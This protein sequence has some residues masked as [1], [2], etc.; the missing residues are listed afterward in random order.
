MNQYSNFAIEECQVV[1][2]NA[3]RQDQ[4]R[5]L[6]RLTIPDK[7]NDLRSGRVKR[8]L[9]VDVETTGLSMENDDV[10]QLAML[11]F[12]YDPDTGRVLTVHKE[13]AFE[14]LRET[15][16]PI[17]EEASLV[18]GIT[19]EMIRGKFIDRSVVNEI[20]EPVDFVVAHNASFDRP[21]VERHWPRFAEKPWG[22]TLTGIEWLREGFSAGKLDYLGMQFGWFFDG[23]RAL[24]DCE[25]C[26][27]LLAQELPKS[28]TQ[29]LSV[30]REAAA[31]NDFL[32]RASGAPFDE[33]E[34]LKQR[35]YRWRPDDLPNGKVWWTIVDDQQA[36][37]DWLRSEVYK[38]DAVIPV[39]KVS[40]LERYSDRLWNE[41]WQHA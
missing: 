30:V 3:P 14:G 27:A 20:V 25:A 23:H 7:F 1:G 21:M 35:G 17:S 34:K 36:E 12:D 22:C 28:G 2:T 8:G 26:L 37:V 33:K 38:H 39:Q 10:V 5:L 16:V 19:N 32:I 9:V 24:A 18:T 15:D 29:V 41:E 11:P 40:A 31:K 6:R 4:W 13:K